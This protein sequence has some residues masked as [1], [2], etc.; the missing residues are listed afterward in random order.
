MKL[1]KETWKT[2]LQQTRFRHGNFYVNHPKLFKKCSVTYKILQN[3][4]VFLP[5]THPLGINYFWK[6][7]E[8]N[9]WIK[10]KAANMVPNFMRIECDNAKLFV[11]VG[12]KVPCLFL[13]KCGQD[14]RSFL[15][16]LPTFLLIFWVFDSFFT[17]DESWLFFLNL[18]L[19][20]QFCGK[21]MKWMTLQL[22]SSITKK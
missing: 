22:S 2:S 15:W 17:H 12:G 3:I 1:F 20:F 7:I 6:W 11:R 14:K 8:Q 9:L 5:G 16:N 4:P 10:Q 21:Y 18:G 19:T 13:W